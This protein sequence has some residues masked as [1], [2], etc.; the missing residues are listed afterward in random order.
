MLIKKLISYLLIVMIGFGSMQALLAKTNQSL[1][2]QSDMSAMMSDGAMSIDCEHC[3]HDGKLMINCSFPSAGIDALNLL[4]KPLR[5]TQISS[6]LSHK[7]LAS[8]LMYTYSDLFKKPPIFS[9]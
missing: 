5:N 1:A 3:H 8:H 7:D 9:L 2:A 4:S 6:C